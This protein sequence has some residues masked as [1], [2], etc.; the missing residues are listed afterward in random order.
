MAIALLLFR[1]SSQN[2]SCRTE[3]GFLQYMK[4]TLVLY[5]GANELVCVRLRWSTTHDGDRRTVKGE[6]VVNKTELN[7]GE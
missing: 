1:L 2:G 6:E 3:Y 7:N 5:E 4:Y